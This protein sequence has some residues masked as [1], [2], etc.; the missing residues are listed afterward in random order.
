MGLVT[1]SCPNQSYRKYK[2]TATQIAQKLHQN[3]YS[4]AEDNSILQSKAREATR[5]CNLVFDKDN[6][7]GNKQAEGSDQPELDSE[8]FLLIVVI[9]L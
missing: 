6:A 4:V 9:A 2:E 3:T 7:V 1:N 8:G 5:S